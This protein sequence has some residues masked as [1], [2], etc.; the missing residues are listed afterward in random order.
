M[1]KGRGT[2]GLGTTATTGA[3]G[4]G[5]AG[6][7]ERGEDGEL[8]CDCLWSGRVDLLRGLKDGS[9]LMRFPEVMRAVFITSR[10]LCA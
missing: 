4:D 1:D 7:E 10:V 6:E 9:W 3:S 8:H 5:R 2:Y